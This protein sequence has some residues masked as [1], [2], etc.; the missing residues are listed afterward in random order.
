A[1]AARTWMAEPTVASAGV[2]DATGAG[3]RF[4]AR[5]LSVRRVAVTRSR[6]AALPDRSPQ[7]RV[8][9]SAPGRAAPRVGGGGERVRVTISHSREEVTKMNGWIAIGLSSLVVVVVALQASSL[10]T[11]AQTKPAYVEIRREAFVKEIDGK[12]TDLYTLK[13][14]A[15]VVK[16]TNQ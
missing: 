11:Q 5:C 4:A 16:V 1:S 2:H 3:C 15:M 14:G 9:L 12:P 6:A 7:G 10:R 8:L 13:K